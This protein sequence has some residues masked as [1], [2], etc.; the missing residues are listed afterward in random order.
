MA[1]KMFIYRSGGG[2][3]EVSPDNIDQYVKG[4]KICSDSNAMNTLA[5]YEGTQFHSC[6]LNINDGSQIEIGK[7]RWGINNL[8][9]HA[10]GGVVKI[11]TDFSCWGVNLR[12]QE[13]G[14]EIT[15]GDDCM[16]S[17]D[18][19]IYATDIH[20]IID[21]NTNDILN[22]TKP[23]VIGDHVWIG[24]RVDILKGVYLPENTI[25]GMGS[26]V[27]KSFEYGNISIA[28]NP[29]RIIKRDVSWTRK[30]IDSF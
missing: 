18:I 30:H 8:I 23:V 29:A 10:N 3:T 13:K 25:V 16:F 5:L 27:T 12:V 6:V 14:S 15:I 24:R 17:S 22:R 28:G 9:V 4:L 20:A 7:S 2:K 1:C 11:G 26:V 19:L 21:I